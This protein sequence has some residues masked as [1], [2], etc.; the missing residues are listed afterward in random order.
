MERQLLIDTL[1]MRLV[2]EEDA[3]GGKLI[4][5]GEFARGEVPTAN[6][7]IYPTKLWL[8]EVNRLKEAMKARKVFGELD[9]P[10]DGKTKL[11]RSSH[12]LSDM[13]VTEDGIVIGKAEVMETDAGKNLKAIL[14]AGG[15]VGISSRGFG[16]VRLSEDGQ[17]NVVQE[18]YKLLTFDF[19]ADPAQETAYPAFSSAGAKKE[20]KAMSDENANAKVIA[21][22]VPTPAQPE[23][24]AAAQS[25][26]EGIGSQIPEGMTP[27]QVVAMFFEKKLVKAD[28]VE[29]QIAIIESNHAQELDR[30]VA[31]KNDLIEGL[32]VN[33]DETLVALNKQVEDL[34]AENAEYNRICR[35]LGYNLFIERTLHKHPRF[36]EISESLKFDSFASLADLKKAVE[37][38]IAEVAAMVPQ[39]AQLESTQTELAQTRETLVAAQSES[40]KLK[41][42]VEGLKSKIKTVEEEKE[43][44]VKVGLESAARAYLERKIVGN[45]S[46][47]KIR[48]QFEGLDVKS[49]EKV[50]AIIEAHTQSVSSKRDSLHESVRR[51]VKGGQG[52]LTEGSQSGA[53]TATAP[54]LPPLV[55]ASLKGT[56]REQGEGGDKVKLTEDFSMD[57]REL[58]KL[59]GLSRNVN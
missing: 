12:I 10:E 56:V 27:E 52:Q 38:H 2:L 5:K 3:N 14:D 7:R 26:Q 22:N 33:K 51:R 19:V 48:V 9:H 50:D 23:A 4:A 57:L 13:V 34:K 45:P 29:A 25:L 54:K 42:E 11:S 58:N 18:D 8:R 20:D 24:A 28:D 44:A 32:K 46:A 30:V 39:A 21:E 17:Y 43:L 55:E 49:K 31:E 41:E 36:K 15:S 37:P 6:K 59:A 1:P 40:A 35:D 53:Q 47:S 16:S